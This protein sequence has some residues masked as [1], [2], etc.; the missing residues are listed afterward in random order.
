MIFFLILCHHNSVSLSLSLSPPFSPFLSPPPN[1]SQ[2]GL[3][4]AVDVHIS[5]RHL[6]N[7]TLLQDLY[8]QC[9]KECHKIL[10]KI[11]RHAI[12]DAASDFEGE[13]FFC[14]I[15]QDTPPPNKCH[16]EKREP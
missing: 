12:R 14:I 2:D 4:V 7:A 13:T 16:Q 11:A 8:M 1:Y 10:T 9:M 6:R 15:T 3:P 5:Y